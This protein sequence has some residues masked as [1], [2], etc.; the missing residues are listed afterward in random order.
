LLIET[1]KVTD[2]GPNGPRPATY[3]IIIWNI[4]EK[5][6]YFRLDFFKIKSELHKHCNGGNTSVLLLW[7][8]FAAC[9]HGEYRNY[10]EYKPK[11]EVIRSKNLSVVA[12]K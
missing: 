2:S 9:E 3:I 5:I 12:S 11:S 6:N 10:P 1:K 8:F 4:F 7:W